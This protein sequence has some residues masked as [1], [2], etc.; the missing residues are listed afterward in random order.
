LGEPGFFSKARFPQTPSWKNM[1]LVAQASRLCSLAPP[2]TTQ[3]RQQK[4]LSLTSCP[5]YLKL[6]PIDS[7][8]G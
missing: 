8:T 5:I 4:T 3:S 7:A 2:P 1:Y 6:T